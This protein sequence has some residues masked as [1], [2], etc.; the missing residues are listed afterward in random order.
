MHAVLYTSKY[1]VT[2]LHAPS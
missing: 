2:D 1:T